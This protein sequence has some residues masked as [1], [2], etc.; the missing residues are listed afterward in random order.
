MAADA[1]WP[2]LL[3][4]LAGDRQPRPAAV[5]VVAPERGAPHRVGRRG[6]AEAGGQSRPFFIYLVVLLACFGRGP[7][8]PDPRSP[9][10]HAD[11]HAPGAVGC[12]RR[13]RR[14]GPPD[15]AGF[16]DRP[17]A[18][19]D[20]G[21]AGPPQWAGWLLRAGRAL[22][23]SANPPGPRSSRCL[24][25]LALPALIAAGAGHPPRWAQGARGLGI[26]LFVLLHDASPGRCAPARLETLYVQVE[27]VPRAWPGSP[28][29][30]CRAL[31]LRRRGPT[32]W[33][34]AAPG[35][36]PRDP[37]GLPHWRWPRRGPATR[38]RASSR[39]E[40]PESCWERRPTSLAR[41]DLDRRA[42]CT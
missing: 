22:R 23:A 37:A 38:R 34:L 2:L 7:L 42:S 9:L 5:L 30:V 26:E 1:T 4:A 21:R 3:G 31:G 36:R 35:W 19:A 16:L 33:A 39:A 32:D 18:R 29:A 40:H 8:V 11:L 27:R 15:V 28:L 20:P 14:P 13:R 12:A 41:R 25:P 17:A 10:R 6:L 24:A